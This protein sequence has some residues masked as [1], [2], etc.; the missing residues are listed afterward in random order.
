MKKIYIVAPA[1]TVT[2]GPELLHQLNYKINELGYNSRIYY[3][4][5]KEGISP[6]PKEYEKYLPK[7]E[8]DIEDIKDNV[9]IVPEIYTEILRKYKNINKVIWWLS[10]DNYFEYKK[11]LKIKIKSIFGLRNFNY[12]KE[13]I[14]HLSQSQYATNFLK[15]KGISTKSI[16]YL[17]DY[18]NS[19]FIEK[20]SN[21]KDTE[22]F[23][24][25][26]YNPK[27]GIEF[28][29]KIIEKNPDIKWKPLINL[30]S[31]QMADLMKKSKLYIDFGNHPGKDRIPREAAING[32]CIITGLKGSAKYYEDVPI[33]N[34]FKFE[35]LEGNI[36]LISK[37]IRFVLKNYKNENEKFDNYRKI[38]LKQEEE[39][40]TD[41]KSFIEKINDL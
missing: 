8:L 2:G 4:N 25:V 24:Y 7:Y 5:R 30:S 35:D 11:S 20:A 32:C 27:K 13:N 14:L 31:E 12:K 38:I 23:D 28:T 33:P 22:R 39:F 16:L 19:T 40:T 26:L 29:R 41:V 17:S 9:L 37:K 3:M 36:E 15:D 10:V 34:E 1:N 6:I 18:I 21:C